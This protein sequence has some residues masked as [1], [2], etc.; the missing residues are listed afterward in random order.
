MATAVIT[1]VTTVFVAEFHFSAGCMRSVS[2]FPESLSC[3][4]SMRCI[5]SS[6]YRFPARSL[7]SMSC[8]SSISLPW[9]V[10]LVSWR[11]AV[12]SSAA[13]RPS[14]VASSAIATSSL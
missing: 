14:M 9:A 1:T 10:I 13:T 3:L 5:V 6:L 2:I 11:S 12:C 4:L 7:M 8:S